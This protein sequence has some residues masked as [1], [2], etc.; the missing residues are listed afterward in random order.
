[1]HYSPLRIR[2]L[3]DRWTQCQ[4]CANYGYGP[5]NL[6]GYTIRRIGQKQKKNAKIKMREL[7][8]MKVCPFPAHACMNI[9]GHVLG[10]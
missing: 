10:D 6:L 1:M 2:E 4:E 9:Q 3:T 8:P 7:L 5:L